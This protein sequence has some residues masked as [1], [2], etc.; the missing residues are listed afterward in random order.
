MREGLPR[1]L[2]R[3]LTPPAKAGEE[4]GKKKSCGKRGETSGSAKRQ[5][6]LPRLPCLYSRYLSKSV[7]FS[8]FSSDR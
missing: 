3:A 7:R 1:H 2:R 6:Q 8:C 4:R 5:N